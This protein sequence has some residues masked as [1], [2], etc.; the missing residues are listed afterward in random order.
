MIDKGI[1][2]TK[3][4]IFMGFSFISYFILASRDTSIMF[5]IIGVILFSIGNSIK[6]A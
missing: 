3:G 2:K 5:M 4:I 6:E 1:I